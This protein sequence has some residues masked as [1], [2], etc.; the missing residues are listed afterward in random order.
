MNPVNLTKDRRLILDFN[1]IFKAKEFNP[2]EPTEEVLN[3][4][5][6]I[7]G[8]PISEMERRKRIGLG[9]T[10]G[11]GMKNMPKDFFEDYVKPDFIQEKITQLKDRIL[12]E[13]RT[14]VHEFQK[15]MNLKP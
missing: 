4:V 9:N 10:R 8:L 6:R 15:K 14:A 7:K 2:I 12:S 1:P 11:R 13:Q 5:P 3:A